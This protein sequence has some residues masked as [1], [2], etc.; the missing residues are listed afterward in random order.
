MQSAGK[1]SDFVL[2]MISVLP[3]PH[4]GPLT[5]SARGRQFFSEDGDEDPARRCVRDRLGE[6]QHMPVRV[7][8]GG[9]DRQGTNV[10]VELSC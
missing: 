8:R 7:E 6:P 9:S 4:L 3:V 1:I 5:F 10:V 2:R